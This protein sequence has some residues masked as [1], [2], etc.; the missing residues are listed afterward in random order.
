MANL[1]F[2]S[3]DLFRQLHFQLFNLDAGRVDHHEFGLD[4]FDETVAKLLG[5][6]THSERVLAFMSSGFPPGAAAISR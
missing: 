2:C 3:A 4:V 1:P 5:A 6:D